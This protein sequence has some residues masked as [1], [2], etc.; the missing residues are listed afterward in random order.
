MRRFGVELKRTA[1]G[2]DPWRDFETMLKPVVEPVILDI[3][4]N[5]GQTSRRLAKML[6]KARIWAF[7]PNAE[8]FPTLIR[9]L[10]PFPNVTPMNS[11]L[12]AS[13]ATGNLKLTRASMHASLLQ[14]DR[15]GGADT[16]LKEASVQIRTADQFAEKEQLECIHLLKT[17]TQGYELHVLN[18]AAGLFHERKIRAVFVEVMFIDY[19][20]EQAEFHEIY[21]LL[22]SHGLYLSGFYNVVREGG[23][24]MQW[25]DAL[26]LLPDSAIK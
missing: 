26:F 13:E 15:P 16:I 20:R 14:Y 22:R 21:A 23:L 19:Y 4:A 1:F 3:G 25:A 2:L 5:L 8:I 17:D 18:G 11:A 6:P 9:N 7:E 10:Q 24:H 12:G